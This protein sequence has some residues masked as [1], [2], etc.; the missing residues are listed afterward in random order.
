MAVGFGFGFGFGGIFNVG[1][2]RS[3]RAYVVT[4]DIIIFFQSCTLPGGPV[5]RF[6]GMGEKTCWFKYVV[7]I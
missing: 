7:T 1:L 2:F 6:E 3:G 4:S 5:L